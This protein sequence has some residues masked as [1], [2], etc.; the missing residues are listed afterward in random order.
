MLDII[1]IFPDNITN[2]ILRFNLDGLEEIR[3]RVSKP[4]ILKFTDHETVINYFPDQN[5][6]L[7]I[8]QIICDN[9]IYSF[10]NQICNGYITIRRRT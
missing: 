1:K 7:K 3:I 6:I 5:E 2:T 10:Q 9:S 4:I 8:F